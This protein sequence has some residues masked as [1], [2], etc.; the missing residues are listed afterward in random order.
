[1]ITLKEKIAEAASFLRPHIKSAPDVGIIL[2][3]G[4]GELSEKMEIEAS[5]DYNEIPHFPVS[6]V[7]SHHGRLLSGTL[8]GKAVVSMQGR[9]HLYEGYTAHEVSFP[10]RVMQSLGVQTLI[11]SNAAG[12]INPLFVTGDIMLI[13]D[14]INLTGTNPLI[15]PN[16]DEWGPRFPDMSC[17]YDADLLAL[18]VEASL[19]NQVRP[20]K[21][22]YA[23]LRGPCLETPA[24]TRFLKRIGADAVGLSTVSEV[25]A[26]VHGGMRVLGISVIT[27]VNLPDHPVPALIDEVIAAAENKAPVLELIVTDVLERL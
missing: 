11:V 14:H 6:T 2:G 1:M 20:Q 23:G 15:G 12:G 27:N 22:V 8:S 21:G 10:V 13:A 24:E 16:I 19:K 7:Q 17:V 18:A 26:A 25:I 4:L 9:F 3:T 5:V